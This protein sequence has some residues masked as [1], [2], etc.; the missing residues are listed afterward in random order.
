MSPRIGMK[1][2]D[3]AFK[4]A[5][6][7]LLSSQLGAKARRHITADDIDFTGL[8]VDCETSS[9]VLICM[10]ASDLLHGHRDASISELAATLSPVDMK[11]VLQA[12][13]VLT[14]VEPGFVVMA[15]H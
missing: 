15:R 8:M 2:T 5:R 7:L 14:D 10:A 13:V 9:E 1:R 6:H 4:A 11:A 3:R 12:L